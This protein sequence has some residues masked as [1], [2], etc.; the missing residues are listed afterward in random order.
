MR[1]YAVEIDLKLNP[2]YIMM[3]R[4]G[5]VGGGGEGREEKREKRREKRSARQRRSNDDKLSF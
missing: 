3:S 2:K 1:G 5:G 4:R